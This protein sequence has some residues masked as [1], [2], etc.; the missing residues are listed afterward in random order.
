[1]A[2][3]PKV[4]NSDIQAAIMDNG[5]KKVLQAMNFGQQVPFIAAF[6]NGTDTATQTNL[7]TLMT[8]LQN[9]GIMASS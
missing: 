2:A 5:T 1:M 4:K 9:A 3:I 8:A 6:T 7:N